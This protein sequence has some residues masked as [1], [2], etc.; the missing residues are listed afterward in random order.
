M[1]LVEGQRVYRRRRPKDKNDLVVEI[2][3]GA[4][5]RIQIEGFSRRLHTR[6]RL[7]RIPKSTRWRSGRGA[8]L[9]VRSFQVCTA[10][11]TGL[12]PARPPIR[13]K[14]RTIHKGDHNGQTN[15]PFLWRRPVSGASPDG[16]G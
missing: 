11:G 13:I 5:N 9:R 7:I 4:E 15:V 3:A 16:G 14:F 1:G 12:E 10:S 8:I 2:K 6:P